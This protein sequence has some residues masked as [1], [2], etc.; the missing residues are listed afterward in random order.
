MCQLCSKNLGLMFCSSNLMNIF[1]NVANPV[2]KHIIE[3]HVAVEGR[4]LT[5][6]VKDDPKWILIWSN[7]SSSWARDWKD[8]S[9]RSKMLS[10]PALEPRPKVGHYTCVT[11]PEWLDLMTWPVSLVLSGLIWLLDLCHLSLWGQTWAVISPAGKF[12]WHWK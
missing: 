6:V 9:S 12:W 2:W 4:G 11:C 1:T 8:C 5:P 10:R 7:R 3:W